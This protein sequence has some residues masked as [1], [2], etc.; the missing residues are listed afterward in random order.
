MK[1]KDDR[2]K[3]VTQR[4]MGGGGAETVLIRNKRWAKDEMGQERQKNGGNSRDK[5]KRK[6]R[7]RH[8]GLGASLD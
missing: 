5:G 6:A 4:E 1:K 3:T 7:R 8:A 2:K